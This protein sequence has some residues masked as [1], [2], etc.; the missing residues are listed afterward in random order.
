[1]KKKDNAVVT[2]DIECQMTVSYD[3]VEDENHAEEDSASKK[4]FDADKI[5]IMVKQPTIDLLLKR[6]CSNPPEIN[7]QTEFQRKRN[8]WSPEQQSRLIESLLLRIPLPAFYFDGSDDDD[9]LV[10][11]GLQRLTAFHNF[12]GA[13]FGSKIEPMHL[14]GLEY[15]KQYENMKYCD[16]P[17]NMQRRIEETQ[18]T[19][20]II[21]PGT[22]T[23]VK[24]NIFKRINTGGLPLSAQEIRNA[25]SHGQ[26]VRFLMDLTKIEEFE[27]FFGKI[28]KD[29]GEDQELALRFVSFFRQGEEKYEP[30]MDNFLNNNMEELNRVSKDELRR[31]KEAFVMALQRARILFDRLAYRKLYLDGDEVRGY[32]LN[33]PLF[34]AWSYALATIGELQFQRLV[35]SKLQLQHRFIQILNDQQEKG[36]TRSISMG[37]GGKK[38]VH[39]RFTRIQSLIQEVLTHA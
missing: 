35:A 39:D 18:V 30:D 21:Q 12:M 17:R 1:M 16:L 6:L 11:D 29:R 32:P 9:W 24:F 31:C 22:P 20:Y 25:L 4:P 37:T 10:V 13:D 33:R 26:A 36:F 3:A 27:F 38:E 8:L 34:D 5:K 14:K 2:Q 15:L 19:A 7:L 28:K 23:E